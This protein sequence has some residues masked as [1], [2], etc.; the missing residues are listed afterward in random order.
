M[1]ESQLEYLVLDAGA[2]IRGH[3][4]SLFGKAKKVLTVSDV[5]SEVRDSKSREILANLLF[6]IEEKEPSV[7]ALR[8]GFDSLLLLCK[9]LLIK[10]HNSHIHCSC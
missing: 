1:S 6:P 4:T 8:K 10:S 2:I 9:I 7:D 5:L 3:G